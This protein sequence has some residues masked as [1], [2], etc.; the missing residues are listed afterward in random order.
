MR[1]SRGQRQPDKDSEVHRAGGRTQL[2]LFV[3]AVI[4]LLVLLFLTAPLAYMP[5]AVL[6]AVVFLIGIDLIDIRGMRKIFSLRPLGAIFL[7]I[8][9]IINVPS[10]IAPET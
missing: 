5:E 2:S 6:P 9:A 1:R 8:T 4:V 7:H 3:T 10:D